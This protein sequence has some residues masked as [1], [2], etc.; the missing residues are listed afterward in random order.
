MEFFYIIICLTIPLYSLRESGVMGVF[1]NLQ[2]FVP[3]LQCGI[4]AL[5]WSWLWSRII[6]G[7][8]RRIIPTPLSS[9]VA[10]FL[11][12]WPEGGITRD[13][14]VVSIIQFNLSHSG[15][16]KKKQKHETQHDHISFYSSFNV[17]P[18]FPVL[19][20]LSD[21]SSSCFLYFVKFK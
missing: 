17:P 18:N 19:I 12:F 16:I 6:K 21:S 20:Y 8:K 3:L 11:A 5:H 15:E 14:D 9:Q 10:F 2:V 13:F 4:V 1:L 7:G